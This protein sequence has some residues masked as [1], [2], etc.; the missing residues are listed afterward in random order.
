MQVIY[1]RCAGLD[2]HKKTVVVCVMITL[3]TG[4]GK[5]SIRTF[6][7]MTA[8]LLALD[9]W[10]RSL[11]VEHIAMESTGVYTLPTMLPKMC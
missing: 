1:E 2:I 8:E 10:L 3:A 4:A 7:T 11:G 9:E 6:S 5:K